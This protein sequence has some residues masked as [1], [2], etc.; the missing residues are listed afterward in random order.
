MKIC[1]LSSVKVVCC[2][3]TSIKLLQLACNMFLFSGKFT[4][5]FWNKFLQINN[6]VTSGD[7]YRFLASSTAGTVCWKY[8][9]ILQ[10][11]TLQL[12][13]TARGGEWLEKAA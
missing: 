2:D 12:T 13:H 8:K 6:Y 10:R 7:I 9:F 5:L 1:E 11:Q 4:A 3:T